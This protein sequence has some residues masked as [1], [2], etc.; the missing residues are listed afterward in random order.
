MAKTKLQMMK[1]VPKAKI[2][3]VSR[4]GQSRGGRPWRRIR[5][6]VLLRDLYTCQNNKCGKVGGALEVD[7]IL[8][9]AQGGNDDDNN[10]MTLCKKCHSFKTQAESKGEHFRYNE[11]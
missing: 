3:E 6:R 9:L 11:E 8:N 1:T 7:H 2:V 4:W 10:L 5:D